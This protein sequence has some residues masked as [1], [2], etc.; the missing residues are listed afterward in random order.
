M[1]ALTRWLALGIFVALAWFVGR[2]AW[3]ERRLP[4]HDGRSLSAWF[5]ELCRLHW[6]SSGIED[7]TRELECR[8]AIL[9]MG[10][11][12]VPFLV[13]RVADFTPE[14]RLRK[15]LRKLLTALP[16]RRWGARLVPLADTREHALSLLSQL[17]PN[18]DLVLPAVSTRLESPGGHYPRLF[19]SLLGCIGDDPEQVL[20]TLIAAV[21]PEANPW[22]RAEASGALWR[23]GARAS[24]ALEPVSKTADPLT[25]TPTWVRWVADLGP[26]AT[27]AVPLLERLLH[28]PN[29]EVHCASVVALLHVSPRHAEAL[30]VMRSTLR[31]APSASAADAIL[32]DQFV[33]AWVLSPK[34]SHPEVG[35]MLEPLARDEILGWT[36][37]NAKFLATRAL[38]RVAPE[39]A[40]VVYREAMS[41]PAW[42]Y[43]ATGSLRVD[44][45]DAVA[46]RRLL[47]AIRADA[48]GAADEILALREADYANGQVRA[49]LEEIAR[50]ADGVDPS[51]VPLR[52]RH[53]A[54]ALA[55]MRFREVLA[56]KGIEDTGW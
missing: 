52:A 45:N 43:A 14:S 12:A 34:R 44:R 41:G 10:S 33:A 1:K 39:R 4:R 46:L 32:L 13:D 3:E 50:G 25:V 5:D 7:N 21:G 53:A 40:A 37:G 48:D 18:A 49:L 36:Q 26:S 56:S 2:Y 8:L 24:S 30:E 20:P 29:R 17:K 22:A 55:R 28:S 6:M 11:A 54:Y 19:L 35:A 15:E 38:E 27:N 47:D 42:I 31:S 51:S 16:G 23:L 9:S